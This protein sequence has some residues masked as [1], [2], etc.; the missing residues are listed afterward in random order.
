MRRV[1]LT[2]V[3]LL[4]AIAGLAASAAAGDYDPER[5]KWSKLSY[6]ASKMGFSIRASVEGK[7]VPAA[8]F[9]SELMDTPK[10]PGVALQG[11]S[12]YELMVANTG[13][14]QDS[15]LTFWM[16]PVDAQFIQRTQLRKGKR[17]RWR[18]YRAREREAFILTRR[19]N[20]GEE[21]KPDTEWTNV[22]EDWQSVPEDMEV[23]SAVTDATGLFYVLS[24]APLN[25]TGDK[26]RLILYSQ[27]TLMDV[28]LEVVGR[29]RIKVGYEETSS[30]GTR[31]V[32]G[33][34]EFLRVSLKGTPLA[35]GDAEFEFL[36]LRGDIG[37][38]IDPE[39]R[40]LVQ[41]S[42]KIKVVGAG[43]VKLTEVT[44]K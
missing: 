40:V 15:D 12:G 13:L 27:D 35:G 23:P 2:A 39:T 1:A 4:V 32:K 14:G 18:S 3:A 11:S 5:I 6:K 34:E 44:L 7:S 8:K 29:E 26:H 16:D 9:N 24:A 30:S 22:H 31:K 42:G 43:D 36:G 38:Y 25:K 21:D 28:L 17:P 20:Q 33:T 37:L 41:M 10:G 19:P